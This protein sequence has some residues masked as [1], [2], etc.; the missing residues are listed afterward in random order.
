MQNTVQPEPLESTDDVVSSSAGQSLET[1]PNDLQPPTLREAAASVLAAND[2]GLYT[3]PGAKLYPHQWLWDSCFIAIGLR[4][5]DPERAQTEI[6]SLLRGQWSNGMLPNIIFNDLG[7]YAA[8]RNAWRSWLSPLS[9]DTVATSGITQPPMLA[10]AVV[11]IGGT[12]TASDRRAWYKSVYPAVL[13]YHEWLYTDRDP[14]DEGLVLQVHPW[15]VGMDNTP[16]WMEYLHQHQLPFWIRALDKLRLIPLIGAFRRDAQTVPLDERFETIEILALFDTQRRLRRKA[17]DS[18]KTL[19]HSLFLIEDLA[20]N[21]ILLR[22]NDQLQAIASEL[23]KTLPPELVERMALAKKAFEALWDD[24]SQQ[25]Y[26]RDFVTHQLLKTPSVATLLP[27]YAGTISKKRVARL[28][29]MIEDD[30]LFGPAWPLPTTPVSSEW[31]QPMRYWQGPTWININ[32]L[33][34][35]GLERYGYHDHAAALRDLSIELVQ[36]SGFAEYF[37]PVTGEPLGTDN[38]S[39]TAALTLDLLAQQSSS[40]RQQDTR[41]DSASTSKPLNRSL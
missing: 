19:D 15:E 34:I 3:V 28:V 32:W 17:Y 5:L 36:R 1:G 39:W 37:D 21:A 22:A 33:V 38:F 6:V 7:R 20:F 9:P 11:R 8:D 13:A 23:N 27:L 14:H 30:G 12:L 26:S 16:P 29:Q 10:E 41:E 18:I 40:S 25:Y 24:D 2:R 31:F 4:H 35:D